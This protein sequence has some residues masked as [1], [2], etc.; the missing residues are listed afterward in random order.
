MFCDGL[1]AWLLAFYLLVVNNVF[2]KFLL[3]HLKNQLLSQNQ[4][5][6]LR[7]FSL[8]FGLF[9]FFNKQL[10]T[11]NQFSKYLLT[12]NIKANTT[13]WSNKLTE[14]DYNQSPIANCQTPSCIDIWKLEENVNTK[15]KIMGYILSHPIINISSMIRFTNKKDFWKVMHVRNWIFLDLCSLATCIR[16]E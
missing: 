15:L 9:L 2:G 11:N 16:S 10:T 13:T 6:H 7:S 12:T 14:L 5:A 4:K 8:S 3:R 1:F